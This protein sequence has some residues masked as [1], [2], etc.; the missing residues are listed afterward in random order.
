MPV[1]DDEFVKDISEFDT[2]EEYKE[3]VRKKLTESAEQKAKHELT[4]KLVE[5]IV[6]NATVDE[7]PKIM[8]DKQ[9]DANMRDLD[10]NLRYQGF[11][12][13]QYLQM[14]QM[15]IDTF[16]EQGREMAEKEVKTQLV[17]EKISK[18]E[19]IQVSDEEFKEEI[20]KLLENYQKDEEEFMKLLRDD[21]IEYIKSTIITRKTID[22]LMENAKM[23]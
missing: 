9:L 8:V 5:K 19:N 22:L 15:D 18:E 14:G 2:L 1:I 11:S 6:D 3:D 16:K 20:K 17:L 13:E 4:N 12:L 21:D 23:K 7:I 10:M